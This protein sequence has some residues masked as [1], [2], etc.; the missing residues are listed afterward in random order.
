MKASEARE[1]ASEINSARVKA[2]YDVIKQEIRKNAHK[3]NFS[4][5]FSDSLLEE[6]KTR[7]IEEGYD[8]KNFQSGMN[9]YSYEIKW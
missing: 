4:I 8:V 5:V 2:E 3:G 1:I 7:L 6:N 9:E